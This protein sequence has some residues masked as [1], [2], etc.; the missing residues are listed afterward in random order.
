MKAQINNFFKK[1]SI[2][3][4]Y[5][6]LTFLLCFICSFVLGPNSDYIFIVNVI[7]GICVLFLVC[8]KIYYL[9]CNNFCV[10]ILCLL[11]LFVSSNHLYSYDVLLNT[12]PWLTGVKIETIMI[13]VA[14]IFI[15]AII[16]F[17]ALKYIKD[18]LNMNSS[19]EHT[20]SVSTVSQ[21]LQNNEQTGESSSDKKDIK[22]DAKERIYS[23]LRVLGII[24]VLVTIIATSVW[25]YFKMDFSGMVGNSDYTKLSLLLSSLIGLGATI[26]FLIFAV[27]IISLALIELARFLYQRILMFRKERSKEG[28]KSNYTLTYT[29]SV[30][31]VF[32]MLFFT[33]KISNFTMDNFIEV[34]SSGDYL[35]L[36]LILLVGIVAVVL[37]IRL[38]HGIL[39]LVMKT[40]PINIE[41]FIKENG[42]KLN[43]KSYIVKISKL[44]VEIIFETI[45]SAFSF[46]KFIPD[47]FKDI[48][49]MV[50]SS[51][52][53]NEEND[54]ND[55][56]EDSIDD[57]C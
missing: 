18:D 5:T 6:A 19:L 50:L 9:K 57:N 8:R 56:N 2:S 11:A 26:L 30:L 39:L 16:S 45:N 28:N 53:E 54:E 14:I 55:E 49:I 17:C 41:T 15:V 29:F 44:I 7:L 25:L 35:A 47:F 27:A 40:E 42:K 46:V 23:T 12:F 37:L 33:Y 22:L 4:L 3:L 38:T 51:D 43:I 1:H 36:P 13:I 31:I 48:S 52:D 20:Q 24:L 10:K 21:V 32:A 34:V